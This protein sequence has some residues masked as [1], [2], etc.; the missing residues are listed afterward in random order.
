MW[1]RSTRGS[2]S[3]R[4][5]RSG[6]A[7]DSSSALNLLCTKHCRAPELRAHPE[8]SHSQTFLESSS[9]PGGQVPDITTWPS[10]RKSLCDGAMNPAK[11]YL[12]SAVPTWVL[13][14]GGMD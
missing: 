1:N 4:S 9:N 2:P 7:M 10:P 11:T 8:P 12:L 14:P 6:P 5:P 13:A 3:V